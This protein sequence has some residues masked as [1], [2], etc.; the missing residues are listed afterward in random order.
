V[1]GGL[2]GHA[3]GGRHATAETVVGAGAGA[4]AGSAIGCEMQKDRAR[5][6]ADAQGSSGSYMHNGYRLSSNVQAASYSRSARPTVRR[7]R[8]TSLRPRT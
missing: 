3:V 8:S 5:K 4:A 6:Q 1:A 2:L 7:R